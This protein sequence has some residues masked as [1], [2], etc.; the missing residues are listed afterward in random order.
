MGDEAHQGQPSQC[1]HCGA[2]FMI[3]IVQPQPGTTPAPQY[4]PSQGYP[5]MAPLGSPP[6]QQ[7]FPSPGPAIAD[8]AGSAAFADVAAGGAPPAPAVQ[9]A[10]K[11]EPQ[12]P[13]EPVIYRI[14]CPQNHVL[15]TP[16]DMLGQQALCP[17][18]NTQFELRYEDSEEYQAELAEKK[19]LREQELN[20]QWVTWSI[21]AAIGVGVMIF[22]MIVYAVYVAFSG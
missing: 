14:H 17:Y 21:R 2:Q 11:P 1:P 5:G 9:E 19:K 8:V 15:E 16:S 7:P 18:C 3:P 13:P 4:P 10:P 6:A 20:K 22:L 12:K